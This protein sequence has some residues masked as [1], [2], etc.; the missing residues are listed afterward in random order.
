MRGKCAACGMF[1]EIGNCRFMS[2]CDWCGCFQNSED[3]IIRANGYLCQYCARVV[4]D[5]NHW[6]RCS[7]G[8]SS[9]LDRDRPP[10]I[11]LEA[12]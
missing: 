6:W 10:V 9:I 1:Y 2:F 4:Y 7:L 11:E 3:A 12:A 5:P 8:P